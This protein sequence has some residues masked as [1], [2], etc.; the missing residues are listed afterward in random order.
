MTAVLIAAA[1]ENEDDDSISILKLMLSQYPDVNIDVGFGNTP[2]HLPCGMPMHHDAFDLQLTLPG[3]DY[4]QHNSDG[5][6]PLILSGLN[7]HIP[8]SKLLVAHGCDVNKADSDDVSP[9]DYACYNHYTEIVDIIL[10]SGKCDTDKCNEDGDSA[11]SFAVKKGFS[12]ITILLIVYRATINITN[13]QMET[14][15]H[16]AACNGNDEIIEFFLQHSCQINPINYFGRTPLCSACKN[17]KVE[18]VTT[19]H[20]IYVRHFF[21]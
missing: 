9:L 13:L 14:P 8:Y 16:I 5:Y 4:V 7:E 10:N 11:L 6:T 20:F 18:C 1:E 21:V 3:I 15:L 12:E 2:L 17:E 19:L